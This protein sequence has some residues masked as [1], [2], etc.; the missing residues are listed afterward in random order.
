VATFGPPANIPRWPRQLIVRKWTYASGRPGR[1]GVLREIRALVVRMARENPGW[2]YTRLQGALK[3]LGHRVARSTIA[4]V[5][6]EQGIPPT[7]E[8]SI[9]WRTFLRVHWH[10][11]IAGDFFTTSMKGSLESRHTSSERSASGLSSHPD[12]RSERVSTTLGR[13]ISSPCSGRLTSATRLFEQL[14]ASA[15]TQVGPRDGAIRRFGASASERQVVNRHAPRGEDVM[16]SAA[17]R[18]RWR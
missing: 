11:I 13:L 2:G 16:H 8:R 18:A 17:P 12:A 4:K 9:S 6:K 5:L 14:P 10:A 1:P 3:N 7:P 15:H